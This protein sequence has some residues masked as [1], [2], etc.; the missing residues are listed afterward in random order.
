[1]KKKIL[2]TGTLGFIFSNFIRKACYDKLPYSFITLD[3]AV[4]LSSLNNIYVNKGLSN[5][6][7]ADV[8]DEHI[9]DRIFTFEKP[10]IVIHAAAETNSDCSHTLIKSNIL[11]TQVIVNACIKY[12]VEKLLYIS[13]ADVYGYLGVDGDSF[14]ED[15]VVNPK[16]IYSASKASAELLVKAANNVSGLQYNIVRS[17]KNY[18][19]RQGADKLIP[20]T[21][22]SIMNN[23]PIQVYG[24]GQQIRDWIHVFDNCA[25]IIKVLD[26]G[27]KN[28]TYNIS[29]DQEYTNIE[30]VKIICNAMKS[31]HNLITFVD[32]HVLSAHDFRQSVNSS[33]LKNLGWRPQIVF[34]RDLYDL[35][36]SWYENNKWFLR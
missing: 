19:N 16:T 24:Q 33:K 27:E 10:D 32:G 36:I 31:G 23:E 5:N 26:A 4:S 9:I 11:G 22:K 28:E 34:K 6:Y 12:Q 25:G 17:S 30:T 1:M 13:T 21:I 35:C 29:S 8:S 2:I 18:G 14:T 15:S 7:I 20:K 3:K